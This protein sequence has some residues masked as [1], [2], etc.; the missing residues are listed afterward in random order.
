MKSSTVFFLKRSFC[1]ILKFTLASE[2]KGN[3]G[4]KPE[5]GSHNRS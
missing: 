1:L 2:D 5:T 4:I 3:P